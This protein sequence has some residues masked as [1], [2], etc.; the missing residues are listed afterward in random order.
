MGFMT[1]LGPDF[2]VLSSSELHACKD[3]SAP[4]PDFGPT[5]VIVVLTI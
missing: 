3:A 5:E 4:V 2:W 1:L